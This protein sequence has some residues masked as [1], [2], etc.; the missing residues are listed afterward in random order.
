MLER[1]TPGHSNPL[2][3]DGTLT[4]THQAV[5]ITFDPQRLAA[6]ELYLDSNSGQ[7]PAP[8]V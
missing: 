4:P 6:S 1:E 8:L 3:F 2:I 5:E 7:D